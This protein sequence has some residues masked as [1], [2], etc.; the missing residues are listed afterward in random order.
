MEHAKS[1]DSFVCFAPKQLDSLKKWNKR[2]T[3]KNQNVHQR[4]SKIRGCPETTVIDGLYLKRFTLSLIL[5]WFVVELTA[6]CQVA[7]LTFKLIGENR[8]QAANHILRKGQSVIL[9]NEDCFQLLENQYPFKVCFQLKRDDNHLTSDCE[10]IIPKFSA[11]NVLYGLVECSQ[12]S[13]YGWENI[14]HILILY[15]C[16]LFREIIEIALRRKCSQ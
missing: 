12:C 15:T 11:H 6:D 7:T 10:F 14:H 9:K 4:K 2:N 5:N 16:L 1:F 13:L 3:L 8:C